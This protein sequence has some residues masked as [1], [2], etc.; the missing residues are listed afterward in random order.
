MPK[1]SIII[2]T[3]QRCNSVKRL[4]KA[5]NNQTFPYNDF[6]VIVSIDGSSDGTKEM[7]EGRSASYH[8]KHIWETNSGRASACNRAIQEA[9]GEV[10]IIL[11]DDMEPSPGFVEAH[12]NS[13]ATEQKLGI[14]GGAPVHLDKSSSSVTR[15][16]A[17]NFNNRYKKMSRPGYEFRIRDFYSGNFSIRRDVLINAGA[18]SESFKVYGHEDIEFAYRLIHSGVKLVYSPEASCMQYN[19]DDLKSLTNKAIASGN[20]V[21]LFTNMHPE[22]FDHFELSSYYDNGWKWRSLRH[23]L[24]CSTTLF[25]FLHDLV[26]FIVNH[27]KI[28]EPYYQNKLYHLVLDYSFWLGVWSSAKKDKD[29][30]K[31]ISKIKSV[32]RNK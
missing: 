10:L 1:A 26:I 19:D 13:H 30:K 22:T 12:F 3:Y 21:V 8:L 15:Y 24:I 32:K 14:V 31:L 23:V 20:N 16:I 17:E 18:F 25:P 5:L 9:N 28:P 6:E 11:D 2:P 7:V 4:L 29:G 27:L